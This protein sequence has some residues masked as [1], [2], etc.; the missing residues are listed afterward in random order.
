MAHRLE[1]QINELLESVIS[2]YE[3]GRDI[4]NLNDCPPPNKE[5]VIKTVDKIRNILFSGY[6]KSKNH[7]SY[8]AR[9]KLAAQ[10]EEILYNLSKQIANVFRYL[11]QNAGATE[12]QLCEQGENIALEFLKKI[13]AV[14]E[15]LQNDLQAAF[16]G[17]PAAFNKAEIISTY[18][19]FFAITVYRMAHEL[20]LLGVPLIPRMMTEYAH[21]QTGVDIHPGATIGKSFFIDHG[22][23]T[24]IGE[25][26]IIGNNV[27]VYQGVTIGALS[28][29]GGQKLRGT[30]R[31]PTIED[32]V[33]IYAGATILGGETVIGKNC[34]IGGGVFI[35][36]SI[37]EN[38]KVLGKYSKVEYLQSS[39]DED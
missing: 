6:Y 26:A 17:D 28:T 22:T 4:D 3:K 2:D 31:H 24:V 1:N 23:G 18:P 33:T 39:D 13:P 8:T 16:D 21:T 9:S 32:N 10:T 35:T 34:I 12:E 25:T 37:A 36:S 5:E 14:R 27:K 38:K 19:G 7:R 15:M 20:Y 30:K 29:L 11:P